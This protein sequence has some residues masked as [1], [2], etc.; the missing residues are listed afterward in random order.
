MLYLNKIHRKLFPDRS[1]ASVLLRQRVVPEESSSA[2]CERQQVQ[3]GSLQHLQTSGTRHPQV[4]R[5]SRAGKSFFSEKC[6]SWFLERLNLLID[7]N[8]GRTLTKKVMRNL[9]EKE[10][11]WLTIQSLFVTFTLKY[12]K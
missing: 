12:G 3:V 10:F 6:L 1:L 9:A 8:V 5:Q 4:G 2:G 7:N 11:K